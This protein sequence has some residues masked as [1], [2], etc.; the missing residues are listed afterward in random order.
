MPMQAPS[1]DLLSREQNV[2]NNDNNLM[3]IRMKTAMCMHQLYS[4]ISVQLLDGE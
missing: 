2:G 3:I 4:S 1:P